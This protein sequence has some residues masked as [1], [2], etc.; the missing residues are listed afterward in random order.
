V[1]WIPSIKTLYGSDV[2]FNEAHPFTCEVTADE[3]AQWIRDVEMLEKMGA[4]TI[5]PGHQ[6]PGMP[7]DTSN[8]TFMKNYLYATEEA[9]ASTKSEGDF[10]YEMCNKFPEANLFISNTMN[11]GV[12]KGGKDWNWREDDVKVGETTKK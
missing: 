4:E 2:L 11:A 3:R 6:K 9:I 1:V 8:Y 10:Y 7:F 12:F 5:I